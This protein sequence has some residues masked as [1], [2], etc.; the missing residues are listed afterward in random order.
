[1]SLPLIRIIL[2]ARLSAW[3]KAHVPKLDVAWQN[4]GFTPAAGMYLRS[5]ILPGQTD[6]LDI[7]GDHR[8]FV[9]VHQV[10]VVCPAGEGQGPGERLAQE[11][12]DLFPLYLRLARQ[13]FE[14]MVATPP[15]IGSAIPDEDVYVLPVSY[16][17]RAD[18]A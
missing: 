4:Q 18:T 10:S 14:V 3:A 17:Y 6:S 5:F 16:S 7:S 1:M 8:V 9:G 15:S 13:G 12:V 2:E 11:I